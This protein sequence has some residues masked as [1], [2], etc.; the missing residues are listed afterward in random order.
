MVTCKKLRFKMDL[1][2]QEYVS[3]KKHLKYELSLYFRD[4]LRVTD[5]WY[6]IFVFRRTL[7]PMFYY[8]RT[9]CEK[10]EIP[11]SRMD[12]SFAFVAELIRDNYGK[13]THYSFT[14]YSN[15]PFLISNYEF[16]DKQIAKNGS[17]KQY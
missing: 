14:E 6:Q 8:L 3:S 15:L 13:I 2:K 4:L 16:N 10:R 9:Y 5:Q 11:I 12:L 1:I 17:Q 7:S